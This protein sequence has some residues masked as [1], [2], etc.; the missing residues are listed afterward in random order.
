MEG[1][2]EAFDELF[3]RAFGLARGILGD[4]ASAE[5]VAAEALARA[6]SRWPSVGALPWRDG[7]VLRVTANLAI[8]GVRRGRRPALAAPK[9]K[10]SEDDVIAL[11]LALSAA[12]RALPRRQRQAV[13]LH[14]LA[15]LTEVEVAETLGI[16]TGSVKTHVSRGIA[17]LRVRFGS[18]IEGVVPLGME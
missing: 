13:A 10:D 6:Y 2:D 9:P 11:R 17:A 15:G 8:D 18:S 5:D 7:W 1:F 12:L 14:Y 4:S 16:S 3:P